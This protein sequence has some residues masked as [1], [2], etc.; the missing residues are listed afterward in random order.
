MKGGREMGDQAQRRE[1]ERA[2]EAALNET[3]G[4]GRYRLAQR[5]ARGVEERAHPLEYDRNGFPAPQRVASFGVR[6]RRLI[7][8]S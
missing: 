4:A 2:V 8:G 6:V 3:E 7:G 1:L 5:D